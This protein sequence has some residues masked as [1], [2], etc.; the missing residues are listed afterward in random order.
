MQ[1]LAEVQAELR[2][3]LHRHYDDL[4]ALAARKDWRIYEWY[5]RLAEQVDWAHFALE[6]FLV[7]SPGAKSNAGP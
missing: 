4:R 5:G 3:M 6:P 7:W 2:G 1:D